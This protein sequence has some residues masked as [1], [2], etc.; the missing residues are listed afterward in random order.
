MNTYG[1]GEWS[2]PVRVTLRSTAITIAGNEPV[3]EGSDAVFT[4]T[5]ALTNQHRS[6]NVN[7]LAVNVL[8]SET[9]DM[10]ASAAEKVYMVR[11]ANRAL[12]ATLTVPTQGDD[13]DERDS[14]VTATIQPLTGNPELTQTYEIGSPASATVTVANDDVGNFE[15]RRL[16]SCGVSAPHSSGHAIECF[17]LVNSSY[18]RTPEG[19][20]E[21]GYAPS[22]NNPLQVGDIVAME[23][24][25][26]DW[27]IS[28]LG[29]KV[30]AVVVTIAAGTSPVT[31]GTEV[32]FTVTRATAATTH[33]S[34]TVGVAET[35]RMIFN[36]VPDG[37][38]S[39]RWPTR[40]DILANATAATFLVVTDDDDVDETDS[41]ITATV[42]AGNGYTAGTS[43]SASVT[44]EDN[45]GTTQ[46]QQAGTPGAPRDFSARPAGESRIDLS[47]TAP[48]GEPTGYE[49]EWSADGETGWTAVDPAHAG[50]AAEY[51]DEGLD[52]GTTRYYRVRAFNEAGEGE[53]SAVANATT[54]LHLVLEGPGAPENLSAAASGAS[55]IDLSWTAPQGEVTGYAVEWS[56]DGETGWAAVDPEHSGTATEYA[57]TGLTANTAYYYRVLALADAVPGEWSDVASATTDPTT[58]QQ[59][60][61]P[62]AAPGN[63]SASASGQS[64]I[65]VSWS[66]P[67]GEVTGYE[68]EWSADGSG[69]WTAADPAHSGTATGYSDTGL[70]AGT[71]RHYR[72]RA[73]NDA[74]SGEWSGPA[75]ATTQ[76]PE[77]TARFEQAPAEHEGPDSTFSLRVVFS[78]PVTAGYRNLRDEAIRATNGA[79]RKASRVNG[80]SAEWNVTVAPSSREAVTVSVSGGSD[81]CSQGD[82]VCTED[83]RRLSN[84]P[85]V[86]VEGPPA[87]PLTAELDGVPG[88]HDGE[89]T[90]TL[91]LTFSEEPRVSYRTLRDSAF[92][93]GGGAVRKARRRQSGS[94]LSWDITV[95]PDSHADVSIRLPETGS[96]SASGA[97]CTGDGRPLSHALS[98]SVRGPAAMSV[99]DARAEEGRDQTLDFTVSLSRAAGTVVTVDYAT[100]DGTATAASDYTAT[101][102]TLTFAAGETEKTVSVALLDDA[103]DEGE[104]TL[105]LT[106]S[107]P[108]G[109]YIEDGEAT[110]TIENSD[111]LPVAW[112]A[113][114]GRAV[115]S[116]LVDALEV[117]LE[118]ASGSWVQLGGHR[119]GGGM[120][121]QEAVSGLAPRPSLWEEAALDPGGQSM[122]LKEL[123]MSSAFHLVSNR[124]ERSMGP[125]L[126]AWGRVAASG[127]DGQEG[128]LS[129]NGTVT[130][131]TLGVD[132]VWKRWLTGLALAYSEGEGSYTQGEAGSGD[133]G[134]TLTSV[135]PY[136]GYALSE[137]VKVWGMV[138]Y[139]SGSLELALAGQGPLHTDIDMTMGALGVR[140]IVLSTAAG[141]E[142]ALRS[143]VLWVNTGSAATPGR[144]QTDADT[145]RLRLVLEGSRAIALP[146]GG[147]LIPSLE[148]G[149]R[150]DGGDAE[151]GSGV[152]VG[153]KLRYASSWGLSIEASV[154]GLLAHET[155]DYQEWGAS[156]ALR[157]D[158][159]RQG[160][161]LL[162][163]I[164]PAWGAS[165][166]GFQRLWGQPDASGL[167][168]QGD[169]GS[170]P[171][172]AVLAPRAA[173][174]LDAELGYGLAAL[175]GQG[176]LTPYARVALVEGNETT[177]HL[178]ARLVLTESL[179]LGLEASRR[180]RQGDAAAHDVAL[181]ATLPW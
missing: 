91:G 136:V 61:E 82:A 160:K 18:V 8:V 117:R 41:V 79:V 141:F 75:S 7:T 172:R 157:F 128:R 80:S 2:D 65:E 17:Q 29:E 103:I 64:R 150:H 63:V 3:T 133:L 70:D 180:E 132:G 38:D 86:T 145:N 14:V 147:S 43:G 60:G 175:R 46:Q 110:G 16:D 24:V 33:L 124:E 146:A 104:E 50:T 31:E 26:D 9:D 118:G 123:L 40:V 23:G 140:G 90:F 89:S 69:S 74:G 152:E 148:V 53:W 169:P 35:Q 143:D 47:W 166:S 158:P 55:G 34:V 22:R 112:T 37:I 76:R 13:R 36:G 106:L 58:Q 119:L 67:K 25:P 100:S 159:G 138:G 127:F 149:L 102:G 171:G 11:F 97:I 19:M 59:G 32:M 71:T 134:S 28:V 54:N 129:L 170:G 154:R 155:Q 5:T 73:V 135:H 105:T 56:G 116:H 48:A 178:G 85:S 93:G 177:W 1:N 174:R 12:T 68:V 20:A 72:V 126:S 137:R 139:G 15:R 27:V 95:E 131:A 52:G 77:L 94:D 42:N 51:A 130:T 57:H 121:V 114:F 66:A 168:P 109:A 122:T 81:A 83:G 108:S 113:R 98:A 30:D 153:G 167:T 176:L 49:V 101:S 84:S 165:A 62:P 10:V 107:N 115:A 120:D 181:R 161:G 173:G 78:E 151:T 125:R 156:G 144:V 6:N 92:D 87:V 21:R 4:L 142:L 44:V 96:C 111:P 164:I 88:E 45:D 162:A 163:S 99:S 179:N 39:A